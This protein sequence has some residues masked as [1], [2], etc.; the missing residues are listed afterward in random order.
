LRL[1]AP[2]L[3]MVRGARVH[4]HEVPVVRALEI[5]HGVGERLGR[6]FPIVEMPPE[7]DR[8][9][10]GCLPSVRL[11]DSFPSVHETPEL[12]AI[13]CLAAESTQVQALEPTQKGPRSQ[14]PRESPP[15]RVF[16]VLGCCRESFGPYAS[17]SGG[18][19]Y[20]RAGIVCPET[21]A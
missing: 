14:A 21:R 11:S 16:G 18:A 12:A 20:P 13:T 3:D 17:P 8:R 10:I 5:Q 6:A 2:V 4:L 7:R 19:M 1:H 9:P 15:S